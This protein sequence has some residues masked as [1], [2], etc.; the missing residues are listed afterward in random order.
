M[1]THAKFRVAILSDLHA[2]PRTVPASPGEIKLFTDEDHASPTEHPFKG[3]EALTSRE[4]LL[5]D[6][7]VC[8]GDMTNKANRQALQYVWDGL[9]RLKDAMKAKAV[10]ATV[11]NHDVDS[12]GHSTDSFPRE[13]LMR[14]VPPFPAGN[15]RLSDKYWA[16]GYFI[17][18]YGFARVLVLNTCWLHEARDELERGVL[19]D[20]TLGRVKED[21]AARSPSSINVAVFHHHPHPHS[22]LGLG[23][24]DVIRN[25]QRFLDMLATN[26][27]W[28]V[29]HGHKHHPKIEYAQGQHRQP[30]VFACGSFSGRLEGDNALVSRNYFHVV[31]IDSDVQGLAGRILSWCWMPGTGWI[32]YGSAMPAFPTEVGFGS[33]KDVAVLA[34]EIKAFLV[35]GIHMSWEE[36]AAKSPDLRFLMPRQLEAL[37]QT[38][39]ARHGIATL[40]DE[41]GRPTQVGVRND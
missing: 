26:D 33:S 6:L 19:T 20:Y 5:A 3:L 29:I 9:H 32:R 11:G 41:E 31:E 18:E 40:Y 14:L 30:I 38:L 28:L 25:G 4:R 13:S 27:H 36:L 35:P 21:L 23:F 16:H 10:V 12:R 15:E 1:P 24:D 2:A 37:I 39:R 8:P 22:E 34:D 17:Q 7:V